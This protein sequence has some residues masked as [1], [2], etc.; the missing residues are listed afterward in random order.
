[1]QNSENY[2]NEDLVLIFK[3]LSNPKR[4]DIF[5]SFVRCIPPDT[6]EKLSEEQ[7]IVCQ[8][9]LCDDFDLA[10]STVSHHLKEL[11]IAGLI[12]QERKGKDIFISVNPEAVNILKNFTKIF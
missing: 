9:C 12:N 7:L 8:K 3:A 10:P 11:R 1:M 2:K 5:M 4:L 6:V